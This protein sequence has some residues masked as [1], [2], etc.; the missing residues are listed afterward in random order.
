MTT[1]T[2]DEVR[3]P[4]RAREAV[5]RH[6]PVVVM[7]RERPVFVILHP[8]DGPSARPSIRPG[9]PLRDA[10]AMLAA[11]APPD[12]GFADDMESILASVGS[13]PTD[14]WSVP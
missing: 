10:L 6:E 5:A 3:I 12:V 14:P 9:R 8:E 1:I 2:G 7:N 4:R 13:D 11:S